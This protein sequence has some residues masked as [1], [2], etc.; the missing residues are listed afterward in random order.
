MVKR[1]VEQNLR[2]K[3]FEARNGKFETSAVVS[4]RGRS[5]SGKMARP[6][7]EDYLKG[8]CTTP[9]CEKWHLPEC[10]F[11]KS[12]SRFGKS[13]LMHTARLVK[14]RL[15]GPKRMM[16]KVHWL[17]WRSMSRKLVVCRD[18]SHKRHGR[19]VCN[20]W[21]C[22]PGYGAAEVFID[23][24]EELRHAETDPTCRIHK[25]CCTSRKHS[26]PRSIVRNDLPRWSSSA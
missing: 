21:L 10:L 1:S 4:S 11:Y 17:C 13:A 7:C 2:M 18:T 14:S 8:T 6:P 15:K 3:N 26:R 23:F 25:S 19:V 5:P 12:G 9:F 24:T 16:T 22:I 20:S